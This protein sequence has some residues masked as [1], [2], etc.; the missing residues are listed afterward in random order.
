MFYIYLFF[1]HDIDVITL[2]SHSWTVRA[3]KKF[4]SSRLIMNSRRRFGTHTQGTSSW[5]LRHLGTFW[6]LESWK[7]RFHRFSRG[8]SPRGRHVVS[9]ENTQ[10]WEQCRR[11]VLGVPRHRTVRTFHSSKHAR[12][13][14]QCLSKL[15]NGC[16]TVLFDGAYCLLAV[17]V[18]GGESSQLRMA[19]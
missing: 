7:W 17:I 3:V 5:G 1:I 18:E 11:N 15:G 6:K 14:V 12:I 8:I 19:N 4:L 16:F 2:K 10:H 13:C 9:S